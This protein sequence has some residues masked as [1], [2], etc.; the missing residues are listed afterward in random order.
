MEAERIKLLLEK[1]DGE[2]RKKNIVITDLENQANWE[3]KEDVEIWLRENVK[4]TVDI[5]RIS[6]RNLY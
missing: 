5:V 3:K 1:E 4:M 2:K 6:K